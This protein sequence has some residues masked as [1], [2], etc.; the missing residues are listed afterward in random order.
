[1]SLIF[2]LESLCRPSSSR[3]TFWQ[4]IFFFSETT[5]LK[6]FL[7]NNFGLYESPRERERERQMHKCLDFNLSK[8][9]WQ[10]GTAARWLARAPCRQNASVRVLRSLKWFFDS[11]TLFLTFLDRF[12]AGFW[13]HW[14]FRAKSYSNTLWLVVTCHVTCNIQS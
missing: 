4:P 9:S 7:Q 6:H 2:L 5:S 11:N 12:W 3:C 13:Y 8:T 14:I 10:L 1:M